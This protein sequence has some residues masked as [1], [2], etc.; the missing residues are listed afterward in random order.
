MRIAFIAPPALADGRFVEAEDCCY[1]A[2]TA[3]VLPA[4]LLA[5]A[6]EAKRAGHEVAFVDLSII[7]PETLRKFCPELAVYPLEWLNHAEEHRALARLCGAV[8][9][10]VIALPAGYA[11]DYAQLTPSPFCV[12]YS[13]PER[14]IA[15]LP[16]DAAGLRGWRENAG[17]IAWY[18]GAASVVNYPEGIVKYSPPLPT[19]LHELGPV[20]YSLVPVRYWQHYGTAVYQAT[21]G[22]PYRCTF[23]IWGGST[24]TDRTFRM[25]PAAQV[26]GD[27][28]QMKDAAT[29]AGA[30][31]P[32]LYILCAQLTTNLRWLREFSAAMEDAG[33]PFVSNVNLREVTD[34]KMVLLRKAGMTQASAGLEA[35]SDELLA[36]LGKPY[37]FAQAMAGIRV[38][39]ESGM[40]CKLH[41]RSGFGESA[42]QVAAA[43]EGLR[44]IAA[45]DAGNLSMN[46]GP[47]IHNK[48][49]VFLR[50]AA[51]RLEPHPDYLSGRWGRAYC[52]WWPDAPHDAWIEYALE[53]KQ[54]GLSSSRNLR[55]Y[56]ASFREAFTRRVRSG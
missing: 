20:D 49:T 23:C 15:G 26:A 44:E 40:P 52:P 25:R 39:A 27:V 28:R 36:M 51:Y 56:P 7:S 29:A 45:L 46:L 38:I 18:D 22:C 8:P 10:I 50:D 17:G 41:L 53:M 14:V 33:Y 55:G 35:T 34:E 16:Q 1:A 2:T 12:A 11:S 6:S 31:P 32:P 24:V 30:E 48:G 54:L 37:A 3:R 5:C 47:L 21:R 43:I 19:C 9:R 42:G 13:E 4:M